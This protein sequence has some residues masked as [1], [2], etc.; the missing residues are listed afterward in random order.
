MEVVVP[1]RPSSRTTGTLAAGLL[2]GMLLGGMAGLLRA[3]K[4]PA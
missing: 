4:R 3:P 1:V 2:L